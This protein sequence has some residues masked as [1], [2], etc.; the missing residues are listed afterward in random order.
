MLID[1]AAAVIFVTFFSREICYE[2]I[3]ILFQK[4]KKAYSP[5][6]ASIAFPY[7]RTHL[8]GKYMSYFYTFKRR[9]VW[10]NSNFFLFNKIILAGMTLLPICR[11]LISW[12]NDHTC[13]GRRVRP[14]TLT[15]TSRP[16]QTVFVI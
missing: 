15:G 8:W 12:P 14:Q 6:M 10:K 3:I 1:R 9:L 2:N 13:P 7:L 16:K 5:S 4:S 11:K